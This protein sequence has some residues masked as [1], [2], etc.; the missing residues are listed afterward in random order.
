MR[1][2]GCAIW[3]SRRKGGTSSGSLTR[4][5]RSDSESGRLAPDGLVNSSGRGAGRAG[6][7]S[8]R[9]VP[10]RLFCWPSTDHVPVL[11]QALLDSLRAAVAHGEASLAHLAYRRGDWPAG[12]RPSHSAVSVVP[13]RLAEAGA[14]VVAGPLQI[15]AF[16]GRCAASFE[17]GGR[18]YFRAG[19]GPLRAD[20]P[21]WGMLRPRPRARR[22]GWPW[23]VRAGSGS[24]R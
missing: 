23:H 18:R 24:C 17:P 10:W 14:D 21:R 20:Y 19:A 13:P 12:W 16:W 4:S 11:Q 2:S 1:T 9:T 15:I 3:L 7:L 22:D 6:R 5:P 8:A